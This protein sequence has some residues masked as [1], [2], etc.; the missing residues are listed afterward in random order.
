[1][2]LNRQDI[3][4]LEKERRTALINSL[5]GVRTAVLVGTTAGGGQSNL[6][7]FNSLTHLGAN[8]PLLGLVFRPD[9]V[10]RHTLRNLRSNGVFTVNHVREAFLKEAHQTS[11]RYPRDVSEF[12]A[13]GLT[14]HWEP[15]FEAP[16][17][18]EAAVRIGLTTREEL[19]IKANGT[20][21]IVGEVAVIEAPDTA[22]DGGGALDPAAAG[23]VAVA[24]LTTYF[25]AEPL[26]HLPYAK[27][28]ALTR[29]ESPDKVRTEEI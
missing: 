8:P 17:V 1:M 10:A 9:T 5:S 15:D 27:A 6:A 18:A 7:I 29:E 2:R 4:T 14:E 25:R 23:S 26:A 22:L 16:F 13:V 24:G 3:D 11:A 28:P 21:L 12:E 20:Y 19:P